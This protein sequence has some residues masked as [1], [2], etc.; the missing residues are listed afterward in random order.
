MNPDVEKK[1]IFLIGNEADMRI[2]LLNLLGTGDFEPVIVESG[3]AGLKRITEEKPALIILN[4]LQYRD[5]NMLLYR[6]LKHDETLKKI[7]VIMLSDVDQKTFYHCQKFTSRPSG[8]AIHGPEAY[9]VKPPEA[10]EL[11]QLVHALT[12]TGNVNATGETL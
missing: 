11:L 9:L 2:F 3:T 6:D 5:R 10:D 8:Q 1:K 12:Q 7:P 4:I